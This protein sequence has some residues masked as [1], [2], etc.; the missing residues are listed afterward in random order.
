MYHVFPNTLDITY[1]G[2]PLQATFT[3]RDVEIEI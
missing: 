1:E 2:K 3:L